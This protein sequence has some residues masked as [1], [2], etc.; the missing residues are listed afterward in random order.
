MI[1]APNIIA[2]R[3]V[4]GPVPQSIRELI[5]SDMD[6]LLERRWDAELM[7]ARIVHETQHP[8]RLASLQ[9]DFSR[10]LG[11]IAARRARA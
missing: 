5:P 8:Y 7:A 3:P 2:L 11:A 4:C 10:R 6:D 9:I 1:F